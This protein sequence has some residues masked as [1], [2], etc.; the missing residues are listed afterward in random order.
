MKSDGDVHLQDNA[1]DFDAIGIVKGP[2]H[3][4]L[5][6]PLPPENRCHLKSL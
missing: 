3:L 6:A 1:F 5:K 4:Q 2:V